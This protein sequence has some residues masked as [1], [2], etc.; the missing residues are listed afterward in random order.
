MSLLGSLRTEGFSVRSIF[1]F[2]LVVVVTAF[3]W[4]IFG[5]SVPVNAAEAQ[6]NGEAL[7]YDNRQYTR[8]GEA[9]ENQSHGLPKGSIYYM[10]TEAKSDKSS[11]T[12]SSILKAYVIYFSPGN[13]PPSSATTA[14]YLTYDY[15]TS[16]QTFSNPSDTQ[17]ITIS[18]DS[19]PGTSCAIS[20]VGWIVCQVS[21]FLAEGMDQ[22][23]GLL[24][25]FMKVQPLQ[26]GNNNSGLFIAWNIM[27]NIANVAFV[28]VFIII[29]YSQ[30]TS[31]GLSNY[32]LKKILPRLI[33]GALLVNLSF[34]IC[35]VAVDVSNVL[36][37]SLQDVFVQIRN[38]I[39][40]MDNTTWS[41]SMTSW[42]SITGFVLSGGTAAL[43]SGISIAS[44]I[45]AG[46]G[47]VMGAIY[48]LLPALVGLLLA[49]LVVLLILAARQAIIVIFIILSPLAFVAYLL[50]NTEKWFD[51]WREVF[52]T[53]LV[54]FPAFAVVF[55]GSQLAS[56]V[57]IQNA[58]SINVVILGLIVQV[59]PLIVTPLLLKLSGNLLGKIAGLVNNPNKGILDR[60]RKWTEGNREMHRQRGITGAKRSIDTKGSKNP[61]KWR[62]KDGEPIQYNKERL[63]NRKGL[64]KAGMAIENVASPRAIAQRAD[65]R[66]R[67]L[68]NRTKLYTAQAENLYHGEN[69]EYENIH[70]KTHEAGV[71]K[72]IIENR[73]STHLNHLTSTP[74]NR[75]YNQH[76]RSETG[77]RALE[78]SK[79]EV[80]IATHRAARDESTI[81]YASQRHLERAKL[82]LES[83]KLK[84]EL[85][86]QKIINDQSSDLHLANAKLAQTKDALEI[87]KA[88]TQRVIEG[89]GSGKAVIDSG[90]AGANTQTLQ[91]IADSMARAK[92]DLTGEQRG[93]VANKQL[94][95]QAY[96]DALQANDQVVKVAAGL[97]PQ[98]EQRALAEAIAI[99]SKNKKE[100]IDNIETII[101]YKDFSDEQRLELVRGKDVDGVKFT[102]EAKAAAIQ[103]LFKSAS[104]VAIEK[105]IKEF[106]V[107]GLSTEE[108]SMLFSTWADSISSSKFRPAFYDFGRI[109]R[110]KQGKDV[111]ING[112]EISYVQRGANGERD[113]IVNVISKG[114]LSVGA[115]QEMFTPSVMEMRDTI[116]YLESL[117]DLGDI[118]GINDKTKAK[119]A[120]GLV[121]L[122]ERV[123][124]VLDRR[125]DGFE[126][127]GDSENVYKEIKATLERIAPIPPKQ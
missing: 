52:M 102:A 125:R 5:G 53:M 121:T 33:I 3:L 57:I 56:A 61:F 98:G 104:P 35:A 38:Q 97:D 16:T 101:S 9:Q 78:S 42:E 47:T 64:R 50:P 18:E 119:L 37:Y 100:N 19:E 96:A 2:V 84:V 111:D 46:G 117:D 81:V 83:E 69:K 45:T 34:I 86:T 112:D 80:E 6:W 7:N 43:A 66:R 23:F 13:S 120:K 110:N 126:K 79:M 22:I 29:I 25:D 114:T 26:S 85:V 11:A 41:D 39:F 20:G 105:L 118:P 122:H 10:A 36:G 76:M 88:E 28:I 27:R 48:L 127:L 1:T 44:A 59:A 21:T 91:G 93:V 73:H 15:N 75:L 95:Q 94:Q 51:K 74:G 107:D 68:E 55:G 70:A 123:E 71:E 87:A 124:M 32:G 92:I 62:L 4:A 60:T 24:A 108:K 8:V 58:T 30:L 65:Q 49:V 17:Q 14:S 82:Q 109:A 31:V 40:H 99:I 67:N 90:I 72:E 113:M 54:F 116:N 77:K 115:M 63:R 89:Y 106:D 12:A 103:S